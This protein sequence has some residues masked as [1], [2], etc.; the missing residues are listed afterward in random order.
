[1]VVRNNMLTLTDSEF[2]TVLAA[3]SHWETVIRCHPD[4]IDG[5]RALNQE[6]T[7]ALIERLTE[8]EDHEE[9]EAYWSGHIHE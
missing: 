5:T 3:L 2:E 7:Q 8:N 4:I 1:M 6:G 9:T